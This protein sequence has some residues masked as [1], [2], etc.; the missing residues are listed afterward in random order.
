MRV[1]VVH[2]WLYVVGGAERVLQE[3]LACYPEADVF[4]L[5]DFLK[6]QDRAKIGVGATRTSFLQKLPFVRRGHRLFLPLMPLAIEQLD[7]SDYDLIISSSY[8]VAK[9]VLTGPD[10]VH[11]SY[12]HSP[13]RYAWDLQHRYLAETGNTWGLKSML[14]RSVLHHMRIWDFRTAHAPDILIANSQ[15]VSR[16]IRKVYGREARVIYP[17]VRLSTRDR[18]PANRTHFLAASRLVPY[19]NI[20]AIVRAFSTLPEHRL[21]VAGEGPEGAKL[22]RIATDNVSFAGFVSDDE[23]RG[24][25]A[26][27][28]AFVFAAEEDFGIVS[29]EAQ[30]EGT[31]VLALRK[32]G[33]LETVVDGRT[34]LFF[35][36]PEPADIAATVRE[37]AADEAKFSA[38]ICRLHASRFSADR[39]RLELRQTVDEALAAFKLASA[40]KLDPL[41]QFLARNK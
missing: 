22:R 8:A 38:E 24:L 14:M 12:V 32:G 2:D 21:V 3:I 17:P 5:F 18:K 27:A 26:S 31:P 6:P 34:G 39:F 40:P 9:G 23:L 30:S 11:V 41:P 13:M 4:A 20:E 37:F 16:R 33:S 10:Q 28:R 15:F 36:R 1:A 35:D 7:L 19:K 25:M 29:V